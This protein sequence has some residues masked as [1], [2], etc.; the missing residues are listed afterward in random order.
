MRFLLYSSG[1]RPVQQGSKRHDVH[2]V[3]GSQQDKR[4]KGAGTDPL[5]SLHA[6]PRGGGILIPP[7]T[8][9]DSVFCDYSHCDTRVIRTFL[10][11]QHLGVKLMTTVL[12]CSHARLGSHPKRKDLSRSRTRST[13]WGTCAKITATWGSYYGNNAPFPHH[14]PIQPGSSIL[15]AHVRYASRKSVGLDRRIFVPCHEHDPLETCCLNYHHMPGMTRLAH[16]NFGP[17]AL[18]RDG[19]Q[20]AAETAESVLHPS[21]VS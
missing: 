5:A 10:D 14:F 7:L 18:T 8:V 3:I 11:P 12:A 6:Q 16:V 19:L 20:L 13:S 4:G 15:A 2:G 9:P 17:L 21:H 1:I